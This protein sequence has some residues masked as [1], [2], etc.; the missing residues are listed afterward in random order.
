MTPIVAP[1]LEEYC[2][3]HSTPP[4]PLLDELAAYTRAYCQHP[5]MLT[6]PVEGVFLRMLVGLCGA[7]RVLEIGTYTGYAVQGTHQSRRRRDGQERPW[8]SA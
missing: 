1:E 8:H 2:R 5:Q 7:R 6:G 3:A 4:G